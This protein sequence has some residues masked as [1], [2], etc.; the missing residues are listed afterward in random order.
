[1]R[2]YTKLF[3]DF[4]FIKQKCL[5]LFFFQFFLI[6]RIIKKYNYNLMNYIKKIFIC[7]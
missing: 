6:K 2:K 3:I 7:Y 4:S 1:M 5:N